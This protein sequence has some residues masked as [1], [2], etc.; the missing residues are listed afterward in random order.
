MG[1]SAAKIDDT[2]WSGFEIQPAPNPTSE[3]ERA[4]KLLDPGFG[5]M[6]K[7]SMLLKSDLSVCRQWWKVLIFRFDHTF[8]NIKPNMCQDG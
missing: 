4:A 2:I 1:V 5:G 6:R 3:K 7:S 8:C